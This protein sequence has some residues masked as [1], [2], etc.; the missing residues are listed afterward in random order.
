MTV[1]LITKG[2]EKVKFDY[3]LLLGKMKEKNISQ[4]KLASYIGVSAATLNLKLRNNNEKQF[5]DQDEII[6]IL[7][8][9]S[10]ETN[11]VP[12]YFFC[13]QTLEN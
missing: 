5:F 12:R 11:D 13:A 6:K 10:I 9:L 3:S 7:D 8:V 2:G 4:A 1:Q